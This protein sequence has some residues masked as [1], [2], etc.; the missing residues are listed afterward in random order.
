[1][2]FKKHMRRCNKNKVLRMMLLGIL[3]LCWGSF[4]YGGYSVVEMEPVVPTD[5]KVVEKQAIVE[6]NAD[7]A[8]VEPGN[9][10]VQAAPRPVMINLRGATRYETVEIFN[11]LLHEVA[12]ISAIERIRMIITP[13]RPGRCVATWKVMTLEEDTFPLERQLYANIKKLDPAGNNDFL[14]GLLF[15]TS[16]DALEHAKTI[17]PVSAT[18]ENLDFVVEHRWQPHHNGDDKGLLYAGFD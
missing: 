4:S 5:E 18:L 15:D 13:T 1:M 6:E 11:R 12:S 17:K 10:T 2:G 3:L 14:D 9:T 7:L 8:V 16:S